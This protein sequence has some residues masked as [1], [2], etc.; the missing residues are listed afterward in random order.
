[1]SSGEHGR[2]VNVAHIREHPEIIDAD[3]AIIAREMPAARRVLDV[4]AGP[5]LFVKIARERGLGALA[6]D[7][8]A[9]AAQNWRSAHVPGV[10]ADAFRLPFAPESFDVVRI[11]EVIEHVADPLGLLLAAHAVLARGG[12]VIAHVPSPYSQ[13]YP[14]ANFW[15]DY[16]HVR[17]LTR[18]GLHRL[19]SDARMEV[20]SIQGYVGGR[21][22]LERALGAVIGRVVPHTYRVIA[23]SQRA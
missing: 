6:L 7:L 10:L 13:F 16:T 5:G 21:N 11:K 3:L 8:E 18:R 14:V 22:A 9:S 23:R 17:P 1:M 4:G 15:D 20:T 19:F 12:A 2:G